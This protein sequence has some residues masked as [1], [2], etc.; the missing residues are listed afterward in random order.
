MLTEK[1]V[2]NEPFGK[3]SRAISNVEVSAICKKIRELG[4]ENI[5]V[6]P[7]KI[8]FVWMNHIC[9][10]KN[11]TFNCGTNIFSI[12]ELISYL[13]TDDL[14][15]LV[16]K[17]SDEQLT[18]VGNLIDLYEDSFNH[19]L[20]KQED[21]EY[22]DMVG[23]E[24]YNKNTQVMSEY[25]YLIEQLQTLFQSGFLHEKINTLNLDTLRYILKGE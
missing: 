5:E 24:L 11:N 6:Y 12:N 7:D 22:F 17:L 16:G 8:E 21:M 10:Y 19:L 14:N 9:S 23:T 2:L 25:S 20:A 13:D 18:R 15:Y 4:V 3:K 1:E